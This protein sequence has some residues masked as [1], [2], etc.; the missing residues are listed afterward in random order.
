MPDNLLQENGEVSL[1][2]M[3]A[4]IGIPDKLADL[5]EIKK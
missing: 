5:K 2:T 1:Y 4:R 3:A